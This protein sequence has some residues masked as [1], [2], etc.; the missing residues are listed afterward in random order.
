MIIF[1]GKSTEHDISILSAVQTMEA[2]DKQKYEI[3]PIYITKNSKWLYGTKL[4]NL[5]TFKNLDFKNLKEVAILPNSDMLFIK[6]MGGYKPFKKIDCAFIIMHG[7][8]GEDG[9]MQGLMELS[10]IPYSSSGILASSIGIDKTMQKQ[11]FENLSIP[12]VPYF[13]LSRLEYEKLG[14]KIKLENLIFPVIVKPNRLGS[15]IGITVC[16]NQKQLNNA[17]SLAFK[18]DDFVVVEK[19]VKKMKEINISVLGYQDDAIL[20]T[21]EQPLTNHQ[22]LTFTDKY[23]G[24]GKTKTQKIGAKISNKN[25]GTKNGMQ[26]LSRIVPAN[27]DDKTKKLVETYAKQIFIGLKC[28]GVIRIDFIFDETKKVLYVNE[29]NTI[30]GSFA[31][32]LWEYKGI[33]FKDEIDKIIQISLQEYHERSQKTMVFESNVLK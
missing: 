15:S 33:T 3:F 7:M 24:G 28:K 6:K 23:C 22:M 9:S 14:K 1:G 31:F 27:I 16:K 11:M 20:S 32:Y 30:P 10:N 18:F 5:T 12:V 29:I 19:L 26:S 2:I 17:L 4:S 21:T 8:N 25:T 13:S